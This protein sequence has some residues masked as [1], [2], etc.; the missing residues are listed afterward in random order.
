MSKKSSGL[1]TLITGA[2]VGAAALFLSDKKNRSKT[3]AAIKTAKK[4]YGDNPQKAVKDA[5]TLAKKE[6]KKVKATSKKAVTKATSTAKK[7]VATSVKKRAEKTIKNT[8]KS[9][10]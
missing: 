6:T 4:K 1:F 10:K 7:N 8:K 9:S 2:V 5:V 3:T